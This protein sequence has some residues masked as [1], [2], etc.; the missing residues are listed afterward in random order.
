MQI[1]VLNYPTTTLDIVSVPDDITDV[2]AFLS[3]DY[4]LSEISYMACDGKIE[5]RNRITVK[6]NDLCWLED[7]GKT[8][9]GYQITGLS[10]KAEESLKEKHSLHEF[11]LFTDRESAVS[12]FQTKNLDMNDFEIVPRLRG[13]IE[14][15]ILID[16]EGQPVHVAVRWPWSQNLFDKE[17]FRQHSELI[18]Y[19]GSE[20]EYGGSAYKVESRWLFSLDEETLN[21]IEVEAYFTP[22]DETGNCKIEE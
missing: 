4:N 11:M 15:P 7:A 2:E 21:K 6:S 10:P 9:L 12:F 18:N 20:E 17:G 13:E 8:P 3:E 19:P 14:N 16:N 1:A 5:T 22:L